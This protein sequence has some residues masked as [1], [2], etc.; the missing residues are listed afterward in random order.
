MLPVMFAPTAVQ[1]DGHDILHVIFA[2]HTLSVQ[3]RS[4]V[5]KVVVELAAAL[6]AKAKVALATW[7]DN[8]GQM[9]LYD[10]DELVKFFRRAPSP[11]VLNTPL[12]RSLGERFAD[13][14]K[15]YRAVR[16]LLP[17][18]F[19][20]GK[21][22]SDRHRSVITQCLSMNWRVSAVVYDLIPIINSH[23][24][25]MRAAHEQYVAELVRCDDLFPISRFVETQLRGY[26]QRRM[27]VS[28]THLE[29]ASTK[30][31]PVPLPQPAAQPVEDA[32]S[33]R[34][35]VILMVGTVEPRKRQLEVVR[36][37]KA[38][39]ASG[40]IS[41]DL[42]V[43][44]SLHP[45]IAS[46][47][48][49]E[50]E[51][52]SSISYLGYAS[53]LDIARAYCSARFTVFASVD[54]GFGL[55]IVE[56][57]ARHV[58]CL[59]ANFGAMAE[60]AE[61]G[62]C[63]LVDVLDPKALGVAMLRMANDNATIERLKAEIRVRPS[64]LWSDY[65]QEILAALERRDDQRRLPPA[66]D[67][68]LRDGV[69]VAPESLG[70]GIA[71]LRR[72]DVAEK[73]VQS[74]GYITIHQLGKSDI[75]AK[76]LA[77]ISA[78]HVLFLCGP[79]DMGRLVSGQIQ[80]KSEATVPGWVEPT[81]TRTAQVALVADA[82]AFD[83]KQTIIARREDNLRRAALAIT[84]S[85]PLLAIII[86]TYNRC[87]FVCE[88]VRWITSQIARLSSLVELIV[89]DNASKDDTVQKL[90]ELEPHHSFKLVV[91]PTNVGMLGNLRVCSRASSARH[92]W[93]IGDDDYAIPGA[94]Q[95]ILAVLERYPEL[96]LIAANFA[97]YHREKFSAG[98]YAEMFIAEQQVVGQNVRRSGLMSAALA[99]SQHD[100][101][102][103][104]IYPLIMR[105]DI[106]ANIFDHFF[107]G[108]AFRSLTESIPTTE[109]ILSNLAKT[110]AY[111]IAEPII[112]GNAHNSWRH[113]RVAWHGMLMPLALNLARQAG[114]DPEL[115]HRWGCCHVDLLEEAIRLFGNE[116]DLLAFEPEE[117]V[118]ASSILL[119]VKSLKDALMAR[120]SRGIGS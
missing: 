73:A 106:A 59:T 101:L 79:G 45:G 9:R 12:A 84:K 117:R 112:V 47:F 116:S 76:E 92:F 37:F 91:N 30:I 115:L 55:P 51:G 107:R 22:G 75:S 105:R 119:Q 108:A 56:S 21:D 49:N 103:T 80:S 23:Y 33:P 19:Y 74:S 104:A 7:D 11:N 68:F 52:V 29:F 85:G 14:V 3:S 44:G 57:L 72:S 43:I 25:D 8:D 98:E 41:L 81:G 97:V 42:C 50:I 2:P 6:A 27:H 71:G 109:F 82:M 60:A 28:A 113:H 24:I 32:G 5:Q 93:L 64:R 31:V 114:F 95:N 69:D 46:D 61:G 62:G 20:H 35:T 4:G 39:R 120:Q 15:S 118:V 10:N 100:N 48:L 77:A 17:E 102:F 90:R 1:D 83:L 54:E 66:I 87:G 58:P 67:A 89:V 111:W 88:N 96:P 65:V 70:V 38:L 63:Y 94:I 110:E 34:K 26:L 18:I 13:H 40:A 78:S 86:S 16:V 99:G 53:D 36:S